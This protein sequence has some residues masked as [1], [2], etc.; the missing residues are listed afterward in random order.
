MSRSPR[1]YPGD[2]IT[3]RWQ[4]GRCIHAAACVRSLPGVFDPNARPWVRPDE[5]S[6][7]AVVEAVLACPTGALSF[8]R[9]DGGPDEAAPPRC[10]ARVL[11][12][13]P[14]VVAGDV[15]L[16]D[17]EGETLDRE[18]RLALCR[19]GAS[20]NKPYCDGAHTKADFSDP[21]GVPDPRLR[22]EVG[23]DAAP[24][25]RIKVA[26]KGPLI[27]D[28]AIVLHDASGVECGRGSKTA[29]CRCGASANKPFCDGT[30]AK[31]G[32][33]ADS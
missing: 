14:L 19:C 23:A 18:R 1:T 15:I 28:G 20:A 12:D 24:T 7:E 29:L 9:H 21:G 11:A 5:A 32:F 22:G 16:V 13:G 30:H 2:T 25:V 27:V 4:Q 17:G 10:E 33:E 3:V 8:E 31:I 26:P 6:T